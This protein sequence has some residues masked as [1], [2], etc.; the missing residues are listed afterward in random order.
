MCLS[1]ISIY[2]KLKRKY[3]LLEVPEGAVTASQL[4]LL[5]KYSIFYFFHAHFFLLASSP[6]RW[7]TML[8]QVQSILLVSN[9]SNRSLMAV[10]V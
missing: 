6:P 4:V 7:Q 10:D 2:H 5:C 1:I 3:L 9:F 8:L